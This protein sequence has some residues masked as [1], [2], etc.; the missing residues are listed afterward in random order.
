[1][2]E[3][4]VKTEEGKLFLDPNEIAFRKIYRGLLEQ[5]KIT[6]IFRPGKRFCGDFRGYCEE[7]EATVRVIDS[8]GADWAMVPPKF[9]PD[10]SKNVIITEVETK[11]L[12]ELVEAD[13]KGSSPDI[14]DK[15][16]LKYNLGI[17]YNIDDK[18]FTDDF[19]ITKTRFVYQAGTLQK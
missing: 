10:F 8:A 11:T 2:P 7:Q 16:S 6:V 12:G 1:M 15:E 9:V 5:E 14:H 17:I 19:V 13:F 4:E 18:E 3:K